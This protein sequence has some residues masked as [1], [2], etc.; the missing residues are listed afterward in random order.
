[1][2]ATSVTYHLKSFIPCTRQPVLSD[3]PAF[4]R[5]SVVKDRVSL[6]A[7]LFSTGYED[8]IALKSVVKSKM[9]L[10]ASVAQNRFYCTNTHQVIQ[11]SY[12][13]KLN[14]FKLS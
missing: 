3:T 1:M 8:Y 4:P 14:N 6:K 11:I 9:S 2:N 7:G 13:L 10:K 12:K 5:K